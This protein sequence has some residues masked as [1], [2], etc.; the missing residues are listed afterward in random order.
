MIG[1]NGT[2]KT[3]LL[4]NLAFIAAE[5]GV[6]AG[7]SSPEADHGRIVSNSI[8]TFSG[9][10]TVS[11][12]AFDTFALPGVGENASQRLE[13]T[14]SDFGYSYI[15]LRSLLD[16]KPTS[17]VI[18][19]EE[20]ELKSPAELVRDFRTALQRVLRKDRS[21]AL[22]A[23]L[24]VLLLEPSFERGGLDLDSF[25]N[26]DSAAQVFSALS[27]GHKIVMNVAVNLIANLQPRTLVLIDEP[28]SHLHP[29]LIAALLSAIGVAL[30]RFDSLAITATHS[31]VVIQEIP[32]RHRL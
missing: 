28:E 15:G 5:T 11:Y 23:V 24:S 16:V 9:V 17:D 14:G 29:P 3:Q 32:G 18:E 8:G 7:R 21:E 25:A 31:P 12:S 30:E 4:A 27:T 20:Y 10:I 6:G 2:G 26:A 13:E 22:T 19:G 1:Y